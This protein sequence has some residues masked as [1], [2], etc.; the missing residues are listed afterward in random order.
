MLFEKLMGM[1]AAVLTAAVPTLTTKSG[2]SA[3]RVYLKLSRNAR[4]SAALT[5]V[6]VAP[7]VT[8]G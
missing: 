5:G 2:V 3:I 6:A 7:P 1:S 8:G 4:S